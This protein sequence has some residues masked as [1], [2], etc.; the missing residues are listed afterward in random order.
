M[1]SAN[2]DNRLYG[3]TQEYPSGQR[4]NP[5]SCIMTSDQPM[6]PIYNT[7]NDPSYM[8][9]V[10]CYAFPER[11]EKY[12]FRD[13]EERLQLVAPEFHVSFDRVPFF[14]TGEGML[15]DHDTLLLFAHSD[16]S[17]AELAEA[18]RDLAASKIGMFLQSM[19]GDRKL[20]AWKTLVP[21]RLL[22]T[23]PI[24]QFLEE[25]FY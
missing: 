25:N 19:I 8:I 12:E 21:Y 18:E 7:T 10:F 9:E 13:I 20:Y 2:P 5:S 17:H 6:K 24:D 4:S 15:H 14:D 22:R 3:N 16:D 11:M 23:K 1:L